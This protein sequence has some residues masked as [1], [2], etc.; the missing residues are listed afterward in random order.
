[1]EILGV[2]PARGGSKGIPGKNVIPL[3]GKPLIA[4]M[5]RA[6]LNSNSI[7]RLVVSTED[8]T[9]ATTAATWGAEV[10]KR[11]RALSK[12]D[13]SSESVLLHALARLE[14]SERYL[15]DVVVLLQCTAPLTGSWDIDMVV[16]EMLAEKAD[17]CFA[18]S[19]FHGYVWRETEFGDP[20]LVNRDSE[21]RRPRQE[22]SPQYIETGSVYAMRT[23]VFKMEGTRFCGKS[24]MSI[25]ALACEIDEPK[26]L[27]IAQAL[28]KWRDR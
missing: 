24:T 9:I 4:H 25:R 15:P 8:E 3:A 16:G 23:R 5:I 20:L 11:P 14:E 7:S 17:S 18:V 10:I 2:I 21:V 1:M 19:P 12:D 28:L 13:S 6:A 22:E 27:V 26:D